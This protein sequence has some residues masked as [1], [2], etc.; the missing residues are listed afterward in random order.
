VSERVGQPAAESLRALLG[1]ASGA[2][3]VFPLPGV[4][5]FPGTPAPFH[6]FEPRYRAMIADA[7]AGDR[8]LAVATLRGPESSSLARAPLEPVAGAG[9]I[10]AHERLADGRFNILLRGVARVR[11][12]EEIG[13]TGRP[14]REFQVEILDDVY[15]EA[16]P[17]AVAAEA[18]TLE[19]CVLELARRRKS[20]D[21]TPDLAEAV[22]RMRV[23]ARM[24]DAVAAALVSDP[25]V[26]LAL[27][28]EVDVAR[29]LDAVIREVA[30]ALL[31]GPAKGGGPLPQA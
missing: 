12:A 2:L 4:V 15:P 29:R 11:L 8:L 25:A 26:R 21:G 18:A 19:R 10:E 20:E 31:E 3:K 23:P 13:G 1:G 7:L 27:L 30:T 16:G 5:V 22:A 14:Y 6:I 17:A 24:A 9:F 28:A